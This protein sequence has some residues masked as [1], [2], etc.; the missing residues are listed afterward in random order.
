[1]VRKGPAPEEVIRIIKC[2]CIS[3]LCKSSR[4]S[5]RKAGP[6]CTE[7]CSCDGDP[8]TCM[9]TERVKPASDNENETSDDEFD[10]C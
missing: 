5:C 8:G 9:N 2:A 6:V 10:E 3:G 4:C 1:M 7:M